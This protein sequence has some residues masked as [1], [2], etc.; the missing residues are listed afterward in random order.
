VATEVGGVGAGPERSAVLLV[1]PDDAV[2]AARALE[3]VAADQALR[4]RLIRAGL[5]LARAR[6]LEA[7]CLR[8]ARFIATP[9][10]A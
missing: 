6:T 4:E 8:V 2:A 7:E 10:T 3:R 9:E 5:E 1:P